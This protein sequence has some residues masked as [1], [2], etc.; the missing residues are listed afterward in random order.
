MTH[1]SASR[2][3]W[4]LTPG[5]LTTSLTV[6]QAMLHDWGSRDQAFIATR[7]SARCRLSWPAGA[8]VRNYDNPDAERVHA[9]LNESYCGW[10]RDYVPRSHEGWLSFMTDHS[11]FDAGLWF[12][13]ERHGRLVACALNW[14]EHGG[15]GW[16]KDIVVSERER[17]N[18]LGKALLHHGF[19]AYA[20]RGVDR[21]GL[22]V[23]STNPTGAP[24]LYERVG[25]EI[26][27]R[28]GIWQKRL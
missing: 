10:D 20:E 25:F 28:L 6:K 22:K 7:I 27:Q 4:L 13:V 2:D 21:V 11:D 24:Q 18:G 3:P 5:P 16:V 9:L 14:K 26:D 8:T 23:D 15:R 17:G 1:P 19:R 12:L